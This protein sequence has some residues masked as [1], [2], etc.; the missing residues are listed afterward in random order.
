MGVLTF[1]TSSEGLHFHPDRNLLWGSF[2]NLGGGSALS[3]PL[4]SQIKITVIS[5]E[6]GLSCQSVKETV[7]WFVMTQPK[8]HYVF[9]GRFKQKSI[10]EGLRK[11]RLGWEGGWGL[12]RAIYC[13]SIVI[14]C[15]LH[16]QFA[17]GSFVLTITVVSHFGDSPFQI[18]TDASQRVFFHAISHTEWRQKCFV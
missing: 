18:I 9:D 12:G 14:R 2:D 15:R 8:S 6:A 13:E 7:I 4:S 17:S 11:S 5:P 16:L 3:S 10:S 1:C